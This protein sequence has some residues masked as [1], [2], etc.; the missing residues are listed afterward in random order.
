MFNCEKN[1]LI[2]L[3]LALLFSVNY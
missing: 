1:S 3:S 2:L